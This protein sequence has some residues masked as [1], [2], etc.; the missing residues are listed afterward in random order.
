LDYG[1]DSEETNSDYPYHLTTGRVLFHW[2]GGTMTRRSK[3]DDVFP[4]PIIEIHPDDAQ[5]LQVTSGD[6]LDVSSR[7]GHVTC[8]VM[9]TGRS[10]V[11]TV[12]LPFHFVEAAANLLTLNKIDPRAKIPDFKMTAVNLKKAV[13]PDNDAAQKLQQSAIKN[14]TQFVH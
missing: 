4:V 3:L 10:P 7:R 13:A 12:F 9:V 8:Q 1:S 5:Q 14:P 6:W 2:H 11:G